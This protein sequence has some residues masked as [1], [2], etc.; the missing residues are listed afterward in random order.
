MR[1][2]YAKDPTLLPRVFELYE[3]AWPGMT[4]RAEGVR[5]W[6]MRW[7]VSTPFVHCE[8]DR[9][10]SHAGVLEIHLVVAGRPMLVGGVHAVVTHP[11]HRGRGLSRALMEEALAW[12]DARYGTVLLTGEPALY[13]RYGFRSWPEHRFAGNRRGSGG[14][15]VLRPLD[16]RSAAD[17]ALLLRL[18]DARAPVSK[19]LGIVRDRAIFLF[20]TALWPLHYAETLD[21]V[22]AY[23]VKDGTLR[24]FDVVAE[25]MPS[26]DDVLALVPEPFGRV[27]VYFA[28]DLVGEDGLTPEPHP[29][30]IDDHLMIRGP[31]PIGREFAMLPVPARC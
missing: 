12:C 18:L 2:N 20:D 27:E 29:L 26:L 15:G 24:L 14:S 6:G 5:G 23:S 13:D 31:W 28:P 21:A 25:R 22:V 3:H 16:R 11:D 8:G 7:E 30:G 9:V 10:I 4:A 17:G 1:S 19:R